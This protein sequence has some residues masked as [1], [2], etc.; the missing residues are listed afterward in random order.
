MAELRCRPGDICLILSGGNAGK[1]IRVT[2]LDL[3]PLVPPAWYYEGSLLPCGGNHKQ[4]T[5]FDHILR[6]MRPGDG[7][8]EMLRLTGLP[9]RGDALPAGL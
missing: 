2:Q 6:P 5:F 4:V 7:V 1:V 3:H 8:D 9:E